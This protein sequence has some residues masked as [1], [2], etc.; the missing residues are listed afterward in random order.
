MLILR[1]A[2]LTVIGLSAGMVIAGGYVAVVTMLGVI[3]RFA[4]ITKTAKRAMLYENCVILGVIAGNVM[5]LYSVRLPLGPVYL[6]AQGLFAGIFIGALA[7]A[8]EEIVK[9]IPIF[10][11]R[12]RLR[13]GMP[14]LVYA[15]AFGKLTGTFLQFFLFD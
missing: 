3:P 11:R 14:Y 2:L 4:G 12:Y 15:F 10:A 1:Y 8:L 6:A 7:V 13:K 5:D 9:A